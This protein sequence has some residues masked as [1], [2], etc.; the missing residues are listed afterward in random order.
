MAAFGGGNLMSQ[1][2]KW[3]NE[4]IAS[5]EIV[6]LKTYIGKLPAVPEPI[7]D[8]YQGLPDVKGSVLCFGCTGYIG[9]AV[10]FDAVRRGLTVT[11][12]VR[13]QS[14]DRFKGVLQQ[15]KIQDRVTIQIGD[16][17]S[18]DDISKA[19]QAAKAECVVS[20][21]ASPQVTDEQNIYDVD[22]TA[23]HSIIQA[24]R[25][26]GIKQLIYCSDTGVYQPALCTQMHKLRIEGELMRCSPDG[27]QWTVV[28]PTTYHPYVAS[29][30][31]LDQ[32]RQG[33]AV[34]LFG[35]DDDVGEL[36]LYNPIAREDLGRFIVSTINNSNAYGRVLAVGGP[37]SADNVSSLGQITKWMIQFATPAGG[38]PSTIKAL[39]MDLSKVLYDFLK[40]LGHFSAQLKKVATIVFFYTKYWSTVSHFSPGTGIYD[41]KSYTKD[42]VAEM[43]KDPEKFAEFVKKAKQSTTGSVVYPLPLNSWWDITKP[44][45]DPKMIPMGAGSPP[46]EEKCEDEDDVEMKYVPTQADAEA[47]FA[48]LRTM[49]P[50]AFGIGNMV[51]EDA[52][53]DAYD[54]DW[55]DVLNED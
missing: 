55:V 52:S 19:M 13:E 9:Q 25:K 8:V 16:V 47:S 51:F 24:A 20:L 35:N 43:K 32:V 50:V 49:A 14:V 38:K 30:I 10:V 42:L 3:F 45:V 12:V 46:S 36:A 27:M 17:T 2:W 40:F 44:S 39:G 31:V 4:K 41:T 26:N 54:E 34:S 33:Q 18:Q 6:D 28:R 15:L 48:K 7:K 29:A 1:A 21:L 11:V 5:A 37:W 22:Y 23:S 53:T